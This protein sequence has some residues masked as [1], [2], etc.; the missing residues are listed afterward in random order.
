M[1]LACE[2]ALLFGRVIE[3]PE[4]ALSRTRGHES[5]AYDCVW[6]VITVFPVHALFDVEK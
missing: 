6:P 3:S 2:Q 1:G 5:R 4:N